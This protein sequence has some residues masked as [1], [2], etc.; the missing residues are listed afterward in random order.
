[1]SDVQ[2][3]NDGPMSTVTIR[4]KCADE[5]IRIVG[6]AYPE[7][8]KDA[9]AR[10]IANFVGIIGDHFPPTPQPDVR[11]RMTDD[12][13]DDRES[14]ASKLDDLAPLGPL[15]AFN[16]KDVIA[17]AK[18]S[19]ATERAAIKDRDEAVRQRDAYNWQAWRSGQ[20]EM[21]THKK[22]VAVEDT[23][24][25]YLDEIERLSKRL[26]AAEAARCT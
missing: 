13:L 11:G 4:R 9:T 2:N 24:R 15:A 12:A 10:L 6:I 26:A 7:T 25:G 18:R 17:E 14:Y 19:R 8:A 5:L 21:M 20:T 22:L 23:F 3:H 1:M 16:Y